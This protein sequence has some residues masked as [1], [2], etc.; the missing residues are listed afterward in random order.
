[1]AARRAKRSGGRP[2]TL[3]DA[4]LPG[5][6]RDVGAGVLFPG[7]V[8]VVGHEVDEVHLLG[9]EADFVGGV[10]GVLAV[11]SMIRGTLNG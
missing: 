2:K 1:M 4:F 6:E 3:C 11:N 7:A 8:E 5:V 9:E 10:D